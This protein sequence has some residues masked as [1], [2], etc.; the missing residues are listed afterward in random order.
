MELKIGNEKV[1]NDIHKLT[2]GDKAHKEALLKAFNKIKNN[3][4]CGKPLRNRL[5]GTFRVHVNT[6]FVLIYE[7]HNDIDTVVVVEY[8][9]HDKAYRH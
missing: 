4:G 9:H 6:S 5:K 8:K 3:P 2:K 7:V 1:A